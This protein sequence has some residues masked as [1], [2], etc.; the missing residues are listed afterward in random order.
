MQDNVFL[1]KTRT[2]E[3]F[4]V[5]G[6]EGHMVR[7]SG[8]KG[9]RQGADSTHLCLFCIYYLLK[10][11]LRVEV[12]MFKYIRKSSDEECQSTQPNWSKDHSVLE[13]L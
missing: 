1:S 2:E 7:N 10:L 3:L 5:V 8:L 4:W 12:G 9:V 11:V 13:T 6:R